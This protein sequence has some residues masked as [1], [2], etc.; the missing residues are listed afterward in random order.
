MPQK[1]PQLI[2]QKIAGKNRVP[3]GFR[4]TW[5]EG[6]SNGQTPE[7]TVATTTIGT[8][9]ARDPDGDSVTFA[10]YSDP[11]S[12]FSITGS[13]LKLADDLDYET[14]TSHSVTV[15][16]SDPSGAYVDRV[17]SITVTDATEGNFRIDGD[18]NLRID[19]DGN[20][21]IYELAA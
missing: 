16:A 21:R 7:D 5:A 1:E 10:I 11:D 19:G 20:F 15:R 2:R 14:A 18:G 9:V 3:V 17:F 12:K 13:A 6:F 8:L 4:I